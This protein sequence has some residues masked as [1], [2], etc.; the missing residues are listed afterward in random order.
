TFPRNTSS[1]WMVSNT[2][3]SPAPESRESPF[4]TEDYTTATT[5]PSTFRAR[6]SSSTSS[7]Y[8]M[9]DGNM[10]NSDD[11]GELLG[12]AEGEKDDAEE[13]DGGNTEISGDEKDEGNESSS[14]VRSGQESQDIGSKPFPFYNAGGHKLTWAMIDDSFHYQGGIPDHDPLPLGHHPSPESSS[15]HSTS[16]SDED[17]EE[18]LTGEHDTGG[19]GSDM[20]M[21]GDHQ[22]EA[23]VEEGSA[24]GYEAD[25]SEL[26]TSLSPHQQSPSREVA[27]SSPNNL[28]SVYI[29]SSTTNA[30]IA[31]VNPPANQSTSFGSTTG[32]DVPLDSEEGE[33]SG[34]IAE[35]PAMEELLNALSNLAL[36]PPSLQPGPIIT[37]GGH[38]QDSPNTSAES[39]TLLEMMQQRFDRT[40]GVEY[41]KVM[42]SASNEGMGFVEA[43]QE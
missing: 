21:T 1:S 10:S 2:L 14:D 35:V 7:A 16:Q 31:D 41:S 3:A 39:E 29:T 36:V 8:P 15:M 12:T 9:I 33:T 13:W 24:N 25:H 23:D 43:E 32:S 28:S 20:E 42:A 22:V 18:S 26:D 5:V 30:Q 4:M 27:V 38:T 17:E 37:S 40:L 19:N 11:N 34:D 6:P